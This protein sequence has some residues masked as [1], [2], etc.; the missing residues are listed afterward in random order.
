MAAIVRKAVDDALDADPQDRRRRWKAALA[1]AG[2]HR[3]GDGEDAHVARDHDAYLTR[4]FARPESGRPA[5]R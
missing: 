3:S 4:A 5:A 1:A 2:S